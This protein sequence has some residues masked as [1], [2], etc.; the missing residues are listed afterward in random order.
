MR[1]RF[2][3]NVIIFSFFVL[4]T[5][6]TRE[7]LDTV[8]HFFELCNSLHNGAKKKDLRGNICYNDVW[9]NNEQD[10]NSW[11]VWHRYYD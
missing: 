7:R 10:K 5:L 3:A 6:A 1:V 11:S 9:I 8:Q 4:S 2:V